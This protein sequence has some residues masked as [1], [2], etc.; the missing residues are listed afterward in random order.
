[1]TEARSAT[2]RW[3]TVGGLLR[4]LEAVMRLNAY[5]DS[6]LR[7]DLAH[8]RAV[9]RVERAVAQLT[10]RLEAEAVRVT[11]EAAAVYLHR[12]EIAKGGVRP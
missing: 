5:L 4:Q 9:E 3:Q 2:A 11:V 12:R 6:R 10:L 8:V 7:R 1:M